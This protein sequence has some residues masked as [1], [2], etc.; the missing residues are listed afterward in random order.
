MRGSGGVGLLVCKEVLKRYAVEVLET[1]VED[2]LWVRLG[3]KNEECL[4]LAICYIPP[5]M[6]SRGRGQ[7]K[8][9]NCLVHKTL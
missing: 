4:M 5:E 1:D 6:S 9:S 7:K 3:Q 8:P 2:V